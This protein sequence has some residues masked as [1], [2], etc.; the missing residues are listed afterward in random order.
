MARIEWTEEKIEYLKN[1]YGS[2][3]VSEMMVFLCVGQTAIYKK[4]R[5]LGLCKTFLWTPEKIQILK[6]NYATASWEELFDLLGTQNKDCIIHK[7][8]VLKI[9][10]DTYKWLPEQ[11]DFLKENYDKY[12]VQELSQKLG[13]T[14]NAITT[15]AYI[16]GISH[17][18][19][20]PEE[21][22]L[23]KELYPIH[24]NQYLAENIFIGR[25]K[26]S[27]RT[28]ALKMGLHKTKEK[29]VKKYYNKDLI[30]QQLMIVAEQIGRTPLYSELT[31]LGL[32]SDK[33]F[34]RMFGGY[35]EALKILG[36][37]INAKIFNNN[38]VR[39][40]SDGTPCFST[41]ELVITE[42]LI[43]HNISFIKDPWYKDYCADIKFGSKKA[44][45]LIGDTF[46]EFFGFAGR[47]DYDKKT[48]TKIQ[49][50][51]QNNLKL[52]Q[53][54]PKDIKNLKEKF[55]AFLK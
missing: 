31:T 44:D 49:L 27:I 2:T 28:K 16:L 4:A 48:Q 35:R 32:P 51:E 25:R 11:I 55:Q 15:K 38:V 24:S 18:L 19:W 45:W 34:S 46:V 53:I 43:E 7:A 1:N 13:K 5:E 50:C 26:E 39:Y 42:F 36:L 12:S 8:Y 3:P 52:I 21:E 22:A 41:G 29:G 23:L 10:R 33:T 20:T 30:L 6:E 47:Y 54:Y 14:E 37:P 17:H 9:S 40:A